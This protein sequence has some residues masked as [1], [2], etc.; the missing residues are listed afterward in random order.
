MKK[1]LTFLFGALLLPAFSSCLSK[2]EKLWND[3][4]EWRAANDSWL[5]EQILS[6]KY[7]KVV[8]E[9]NQ[10]ISV[11]MRWLNDRSKTEGNLTPLYTSTVNVKYKGW[12]YDGMPFDSSYLQ[13]D[14]VATLQLTNLIAGWVI[15]MEQMHVGDKVEVLVPYEAGYGSSAIGRILPYSVLR[16]E[17][18]LRDI[19][20][21]E[22]K[23]R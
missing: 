1:T 22:I 13:T 5:Q 10:D 14:S 20:A 6:G 16:F 17:M 21:Y 3:Y 7:Q 18:E 19:P 9:W 23:Q 15:A 11:N 8:P 4:K 12:L 2:E